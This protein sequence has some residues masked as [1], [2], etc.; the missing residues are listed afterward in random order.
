MGVGVHNKAKSNKGVATVYIPQSAFPHS[1]RLHRYATNKLLCRA[2]F[3]VPTGNGKQNAYLYLYI[4]HVAQ[5]EPP[6]AW[7]ND[8]IYIV[9]GSGVVQLWTLSKTELKLEGGNPPY[10]EPFNMQRLI[11]HWMP[12]PAVSGLFGMFKCLTHQ[13]I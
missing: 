4:S 11:G 7:T 10:I 8:V 9:R 13:C 2:Y 3:Q 5:D 12:Y 1:N 6:D